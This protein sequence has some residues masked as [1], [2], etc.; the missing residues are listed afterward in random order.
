MF[1]HMVNSHHIHCRGEEAGQERGGA[2]Q[3]ESPLQV[4]LAT[5]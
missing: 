5:S 2:C 1:V 4:Y 3:L